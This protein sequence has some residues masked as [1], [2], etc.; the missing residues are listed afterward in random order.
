VVISCLLLD[1]AETPRVVFITVQND[2]FSAAVRTRS[3]ACYCHAEQTV[4]HYG[5]IECKTSLSNWRLYF[6]HWIFS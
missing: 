3:L 1:I 5:S 6:W 4:S 2:K